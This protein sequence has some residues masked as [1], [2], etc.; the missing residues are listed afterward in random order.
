MRV[1]INM[2]GSVLAS[3]APNV[4]RIRDFAD[5][6]ISLKEEGY[7]IMVVV[8]GG[9]L[10]RDYIASAK[11]LG[12]DWRLSDEIGIAATR[13]NAMLVTMALGEHALRNIPL[14]TGIDRNPNKISV[15]GGV[16]PGQTTDAV[17]ADLSVNCGADLLL[18]ATN[19]D[20]VYDS[21]PKKNPKAKKIDQMDSGRL[22]EIVGGPHSPGMTAVVDPTAAVTIHK[23]GIKTIVVDGRSLGNI[24]DAIR[25]KGHGGTVI[26]P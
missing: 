1:V 20:G 11:M 2:G 23:H 14:D 24:E 10:A 13:M 19:V 4:K 16:E 3:P 12:S 17:A 22:L 25:G 9:K 15:I 21:D 6:L 7:D 26:L 8:G 5:L 18:I